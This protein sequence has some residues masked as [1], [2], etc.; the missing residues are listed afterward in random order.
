MRYAGSLLDAWLARLESLSPVEIVLGL[1]RVAVVLER[2]NLRLPETVLHVTGTNGKGSTVVMLEALLQRSGARTGAYL[3]PHI[4]R[5]NERIR[6]DGEEAGDEAIMEA[7]EWVDA[8][9][10]G[11][12]LTYFEFGTL[13][14]LVV[15]A[16]AGVDAAVLE[17]GMG[18][19]LDA[20]NAVEPTA[21]LITNVALDHCAWLGDSVEKI[22]AE[23]AG[24][25]RSGKPIVYASTEMPAAIADRAAA[26]G[27]RLIAAGRDYQWTADGDSWSWHGADTVLNGLHR[28]SLAG[29]IQLVNASG[30]LALLEA[31]G[32]GRLL[33]TDVVNAALASL[34]LAG[35]MQRIDAGGEWLLDVAHNPAAAR[36]LAGAL[37]ALPAAARCVAIIGMLDDKDVEGVATALGAAVDD[38][39]VMTAESPR[40]IPAGEL[41][42]RIANASNRPCL[43][44]DSLDQA[45]AEAR[46]RAGPAGRVLVTGSFYLVGP[47]TEALALY[48][49]RRGA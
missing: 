47:V 19:R 34:D 11:I 35:R 43:V 44:A 15:F 9:R 49:P 24:I 18:G 23:K 46:D 31:A 13:A 33:Q 40:A 38:W 6:I 22:A 48:S 12:P 25:M 45:L 20:V 3:S 36:V 39:V 27:A 2:L 5:Y 42:R 21:G 29:D 26:T 30:V 41:A 8:N 7:F 32:F 1:E 14:A 37:A 17:I 16:D 28:P 10:D 4:V